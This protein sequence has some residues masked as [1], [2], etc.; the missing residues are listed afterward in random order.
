MPPIGTERLAL[1]LL[2]Q[3]DPLSAA[4][5]FSEP[6][7][8][9]AAAARLIH[10]RLF[11]S[12]L[13]LALGILGGIAIGA[14]RTAGPAHITGACIGLELAAAHGGIDELMRR[15][16]IHTLTSALNPYRHLFHEQ[17]ESVV[18]TCARLRDWARP[19]V[20]SSRGG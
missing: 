18:E 11:T 8:W 13:A 14:Y 9:P 19:E 20:P 2:N 1:R 16:I 7:H 5:A 10:R 6:G 12:L 15:R 4:A 17:R 3:R